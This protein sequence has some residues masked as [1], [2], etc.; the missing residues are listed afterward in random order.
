MLIRGENVFLGYWEMPEKTEESFREGWFRT[1]DLGFQ[2]PDDE[3]RLY[4]V[5]RAKELI[6]TG[7][8]NVYPKEIENILECQQAV[9]E[10]AVIGLPDE[11]FGEKVV[12]AIAL[13]DEISI[14]ADKLIEYCKGRL[15]P[16]KCP[17]QIFFVSELPRNAMGKI[18]KNI[19]VQQ[20]LAIVLS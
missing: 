1:G 12:A 13:K 17:K 19:L 4:L 8:F 9:K 18:Q 15:A 2:D 7:G 6:I 16:Y 10:A 11:D 20:I 5:G 3:S 14:T